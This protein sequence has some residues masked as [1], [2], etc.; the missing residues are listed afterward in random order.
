M[1]KISS[2]DFPDVSGYSQDISG[3]RQFEE[4]LLEGKI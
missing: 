1:G 4:D 3:I 2:L